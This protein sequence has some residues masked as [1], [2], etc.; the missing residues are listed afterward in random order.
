MAASDGGRTAYRGF[1]YQIEVTVWLL[2]EAFFVRNGH[3]SAT[4]ESERDNDVELDLSGDLVISTIA[5]ASETWICAIK[6]RRA[7]HWTYGE[8]KEIV[9]GK[10]KSTREYP[11]ATLDREPNARFFF[12]TEGAVSPDVQ[13]LLD[14]SGIWRPRGGGTARTLKKLFPVRDRIAVRGQVT[15]EFMDERVPKILRHHLR[16]PE[17]RC[18]DA[19]RA[20]R[21]AV[22][23]R[24]RTPQSL[25]REELI[26]IAS[27][28]GGWPDSDRPQS[29]VEPSV[30]AELRNKLQTHHRLLVLG[31]PGTGKSTAAKELVRELR[32]EELPFEALEPSSPGELSRVRGRTVIWVDDP[33]GRWTPCDL[34]LRHRWLTEF[35][36]L[37]C[38]PDLKLVVT[39]RRGF[40]GEVEPGTRMSDAV[41]DFDAAF[42]GQERDLLAWHLQKHNVAAELRDHLLSEAVLWRVSSTLD[43]PLAYDRFAFRIRNETHLSTSQLRAALRASHDEAV[44]KEVKAFLAKMRIDVRLGALVVAWLLSL[45]ERGAE[46]E[47]RAHDCQRV[48]DKAGHLNVDVRRAH[49]LLEERG[50]LAD[51]PGYGGVALRDPQLAECLEI[52]KEHEAD[53]CRLAATLRDGW[54]KAGRSR[55]VHQL[56]CEVARDYRDEEDLLTKLVLAMRILQ[57]SES[58]RLGQWRAPDWSAALSAQ[59][60]SDPRTEPFIRGRLSADLAGFEQISLPD[61]HAFAEFVCRHANLK[62]FF[63]NEAK[64][65]AQSGPLM[66]HDVAAYGYAR[67]AGDP[68]MLAREAGELYKAALVEPLPEGDEDDPFFDE[69]RYFAEQQTM[70]WADALAAAALVQQGAAFAIGRT[71][72]VVWRQVARLAKQ[73]KVT[74]AV[75]EACPREMLAE[76]TWYLPDEAQLVVLRRIPAAR[77]VEFLATECSNTPTSKLEHALDDRIA[78]TGRPEKVH[79]AHALQRTRFAVELDPVGRTALDLLMDPSQVGFHSPEVTALLREVEALEPGWVQGRAGV[80]LVNVDESFSERLRGHLGGEDLDAADGVAGALPFIRSDSLRH[81]LISLGLRHPRKRI[82]MTSLESAKGVADI[83]V[84]LAVVL[85][86]QSDATQSVRLKAIGVLATVKDT[87][88]VRTLTELCDDQ[89]AFCDYLAPND[90]ERPP[91]YRFAAAARAALDAMNAPTVAD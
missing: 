26:R 76:C 66:H 21:E 31:E 44:A 83:S 41:I 88:G 25:K 73:L 32:T 40:A 75:M 19:H 65:R 80:A 68:D 43:R 49:R 4:V 81:E 60:Q 85:C 7:G 71:E 27:D 48:L 10:A 20:M 23:D 46:L 13:A 78:S 74:A 54:A 57:A 89:T 47:A 55:W 45:P 14:D 58:W 8:L 82:R 1:E 2:L 87:I 11:A 70:G 16:V 52:A 36:N 63:A 28:H 86:A 6:T 50:W 72:R 39:A 15:K 5:A 62:T 69:N 42:R 38:G 18:D 64:K 56:V 53:A 59:V 12:V 84:R 51:R 61:Q 9:F 67:T 29:F 79:L 35:E 91:D 30:W 24:M 37:K 34:E 33:F 90:D 3:G 77:L 22:A 17:S